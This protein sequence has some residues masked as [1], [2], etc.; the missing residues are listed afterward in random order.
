MKI[1]LLNPGSPVHKL[2]AS[3]SRV[4]EPFA[5]LGLAYLVAVLREAR[6]QVS[7]FD[8]FALKLSNGDLVEHVLR[9]EPDLVGISC[10]TPNVPDILTIIGELKEKRPQV[11]I[12]LGNL[13][14]ML[15]Q[16]ELLADSRVDFIIRGEGEIALPEI[17][18]KLENGGD[19]GA[20]L[21]VSSPGRLTSDLAELPDLD[22][23]PF[24]AWELFP[25]DLYQA[26]PLF[27][28]SKVL[29]AVQASRGC[30]YKCYFCCQNTIVPNSRSR[31]IVKVVDEIENNLKVHGKD[32]FWFSDAIFPLSK[33]YGHQLADELITRGLSEK[34]KWVTE[35]RVDSVDVDLLRHLKEA[36]LVMAIYGFEVG[37]P[38]IL[39]FIKPGATIELARS[40]MAATKETGLMSL[41]LFML[42]LPG[43]TEQTIERT[44]RFAEELDPTYAK[45]N[46]AIP[47]PGSRFFNDFEESL[48]NPGRFQMYNPWL[49]EADGQPLY[50]PE[51]CT[52]K[53]LEALQKKAMRRFYLRPVKMLRLL[54]SGNVSFRHLLRGA[55][56]LVEG[57]L[58]RGR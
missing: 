52:Q 53:Q 42:G 11:K 30:P 35:C 31:S 46:R 43:E 13:H 38:E 56:A 51:N 39:Q 37:D 29:L 47:Y 57:L 54:V 40:A 45:F 10:L 2:L 4:E 8:Q 5:P 25:L 48:A 14:A 32:F 18:D 55:L 50:V 41:G 16:E 17:I 27:S 6:H 34:V 12:V 26:P 1:S 36:G 49:T 33:K 9:A 22:F 3:Y 21:G 20:V 24:P 7:V 28:F 15:Y 58:G 23:L 19:P 44:I